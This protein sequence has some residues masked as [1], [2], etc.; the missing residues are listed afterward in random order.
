MTW[1][2]V[3][4]A[5]AE[6]RHELVLTGASVSKLIKRTGGLD[7]HLFDLCHLNYLSVTQTC[8]YKI[9]DE[10]GLLTNLT[11]LV[12]HSNEIAALSPAI[13]KLAKLKLLDCSRNK[14]AE[15]PRELDSLPQLSTMN[16][17]SNCLCTL[18]SQSANTKLS[19]LDLSNNRFET[20]PDVCHAELVH[21]S[22]IRV[23]G[24]AIT[25]IP[26]AIGQLQALK[27]LN[28]ADNAISGNSAFQKNSILCDCRRTDH[29]FSDFKRF[30]EKYFI[31]TQL[32][33]ANWRTVV[34]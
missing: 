5:A 32:Y 3:K 23:N 30:N 28:V 6:N 2:A 9:P 25:A 11:A 15:L 18:P 22:E 14:L 16:L 24:N 13:G 17:A 12:L 21:L 29:F 26:A 10:I 19:V 1:D 8:L 4:Q 7:R 20:F 34:N 27:I 31:F 33:R